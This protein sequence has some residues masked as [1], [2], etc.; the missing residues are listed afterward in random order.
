ML[1]SVTEQIGVLMTI[2]HKEIVFNKRGYAA[3]YR[4]DKHPSCFFSLYNGIVYLVDFAHVKTHWNYQELLDVLHLHY[5]LGLPDTHTDIEPVIAQSK[6]S[7]IQRIWLHAD[8]D[9]W[10]QYGISLTQLIEDKVIPVAFVEG[11]NKYGEVYTVIPYD[12]CYAYTEFEGERLKVYRP[13]QD[14]KHKW[15]S[16]CTKNDIGSIKHIDNKAEYIVIT[17][18]YK[19]CRVLRNLNI[20]AV[21]FQNEGMKPRDELLQEFNRFSRKI[22]F[23]D[24]DNAGIGAAI[25]IKNQLDKLN[26]Q[27]VSVITLPPALLQYHIKDISDLYSRRGKREAVLFLKQKE[28]L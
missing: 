21:W 8:M 14:K 12:I 19:D 18:S 17:K 24:N 27:G 5:P 7:C 3:P 28:L 4:L 20:N 6:I 25:R 9:Y 13:L 16:T 23:F 26:M 1:A 11:M 2:F 10:Q 22:I 15:I